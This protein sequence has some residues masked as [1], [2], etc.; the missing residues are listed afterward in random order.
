MTADETA[1]V[2][3]GLRERRRRETLRQISD[4]ALD[5]FERRGVAGTTVDDI[6]EAAGVS[7]RT[8]FRYFP[9]KEDAV[10]VDDEQ[11]EAVMREALAAIR[12]GAPVVTAMEVAWLTLVDGFM[13]DDAARD[14]FLRTRRL[15]GAEP[16]V[17]AIAL[18]RDSEHVQTLTDAAVAATGGASD[19]LTAQALVS[20]VG[21]TVRI[22]FDEWAR[23]AEED[24]AADVR[25]I[26]LELRRGVSEYAA[27]LLEG[28]P[29][30]RSSE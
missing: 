30:I 16:T 7:P 1:P 24:P 25:E 14:R 6:A 13:R 15:I 3:L 4:A 23:R 19:A 27:Q 22:A 28:P 21:T 2:P 20:M 12:A 17:L 11:F 29:R 9:T 8:F 18:R 26:Y 5:L 10:F